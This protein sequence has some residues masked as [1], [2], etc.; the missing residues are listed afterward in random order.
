MTRA[1][2]IKVFSTALFS[3]SIYNSSALSQAKKFH[4][5]GGSAERTRKK[6]T[7]R[8][9]KEL[10]T[11][12][13][14]SVR[15]ARRFSGILH[16][17]GAEMQGAWIKCLQSTLIGKS[18]RIKWK[19]QK[20]SVSCTVHW[21]FKGKGNGFLCRAE[22]KED[23]R[24]HLGVALHPADITGRDRSNGS[25]WGAWMLQLTTRPWREFKRTF[26]FNQVQPEALFLEKFL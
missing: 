23:M 11:D 19:Y 4:G 10:R 17:C 22:A 5:V 26:L 12:L 7:E 16:D 18:W 24:I 3:I 2:Y 6:E 25:V 15:T 9:K 1:S 14:A 21:P 8:R 20:W 13:K